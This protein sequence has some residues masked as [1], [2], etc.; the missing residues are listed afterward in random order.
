M[1]CKYTPERTR[2]KTSDRLA[3]PY[4]GF[5]LYAHPSCNW[6]KKIRGK[7]HYFAR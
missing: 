4:N 7:F 5:P 6:A 2:R 1:S 3:K